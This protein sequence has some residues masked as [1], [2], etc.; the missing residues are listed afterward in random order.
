MSFTPLS[1]IVYVHH[2]SLQVRH[3]V[4]EVR[5]SGT[6][7]CLSAE[8]WIFKTYAVHCI[9]LLIAS[10]VHE[11]AKIALPLRRWMITHIRIALSFFTDMYRKFTYSGAGCP[12]CTGAGVPFHWPMCLTSSNNSSSPTVDNVVMLVKLLSIISWHVG[13]LKP[14]LPRAILK[15]SMLIDE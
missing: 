12:A 3:C 5:M 9:V 7:G 10:L 2:D 1:C 15:P 6:C 11:V 8:T 4:N 13:R 14:I